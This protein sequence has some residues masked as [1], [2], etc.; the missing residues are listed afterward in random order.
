MEKGR[1]WFADL[2]AA[3]LRDELG[4]ALD[5]VAAPLHA[6]VDQVVTDAARR[7]FAPMH[8]HIDRSV[9]HLADEAVERLAALLWPGARRRR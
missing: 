1:D 5:R 9:D 7:A 8:R 4:K 3:P 6:K 2:V